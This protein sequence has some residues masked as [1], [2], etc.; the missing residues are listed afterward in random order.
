MGATSVRVVDRGHRA[1]MTRLASMKAAT[2]K[3]GIYGAEASKPHGHMTNVE[4]A[5]VHEFGAGPIPQ[6]SFIRATVDA[7]RPEIAA[8]QRRIAKG[9]KDGRVDVRTGLGLLGEDVL[10]RM[11]ARIRAHI[12]PPLQPETIRRKKSS[13]P[14]IDS[15]QLL[16]SLA[17][18]LEGVR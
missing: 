9:V 18:S 11:K 15:G 1:L 5:A 16:N 10:N 4:V 3:V 8:I 13:T 6:R 17:W 12:D 14:L 7:N 2:V